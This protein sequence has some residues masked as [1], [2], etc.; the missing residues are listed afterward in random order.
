MVA[1]NR[2]TLW[3]AV[4]TFSNW[5][6]LDG[7]STLFPMSTLAGLGCGWFV[8][9]SRAGQCVDTLIRTNSLTRRDQGK[10]DLVTFSELC[11]SWN[12]S[13]TICLL[14]INMQTFAVN[15]NSVVWAVLL[16]V[17]AHWHRIPFLGIQPSNVPS[18]GSLEHITQGTDARWIQHNE[19]GQ[20]GLG[21]RQLP[22]WLHCYLLPN[23]SPCDRTLG[24]WTLDWNLTKNTIPLYSAYLC[25]ANMPIRILDTLNIE[26][27]IPK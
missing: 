17:S 21:N 6:A 2:Q 7:E 10:R 19:Q 5:P 9:P 1:S 4:V 23:T 27:H 26:P 24:P 20:K 12:G 3:Y 14:G 8:R 18:I 25:G 16:C 15:C 22:K 11:L 13:D